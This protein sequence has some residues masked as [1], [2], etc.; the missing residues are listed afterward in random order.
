M[1]LN[2]EIQKLQLWERDVDFLNGVLD[3]LDYL[4]KEKIIEK[5]N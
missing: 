3:C 1:Q 2:T 5:N 4:I